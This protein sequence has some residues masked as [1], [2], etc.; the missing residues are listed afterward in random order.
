MRYNFVHS[1]SQFSRNSLHSWYAYYASAGGTDMKG[2]M[3][4]FQELTVGSGDLLTKNLKRKQI[5]NTYLII[6]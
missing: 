3:L 2:Q 6:C 4:V 5:I 1:F